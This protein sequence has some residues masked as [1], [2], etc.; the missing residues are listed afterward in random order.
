MV[1][2]LSTV[3]N[4][5]CALSAINE[6]NKQVNESNKTVN[7]N[8]KTV[9]EN[10]NK[11]NEKRGIKSNR[12]SNQYLKILE[13]FTTIFYTSNR[14]QVDFFPLATTILNK[15]SGHTELLNESSSN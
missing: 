13:Q 15:F 3:S 12:L 4:K 9:N 1:L 7:E 2:V 10:H 14:I 8:L 6:N 5:G 11:I